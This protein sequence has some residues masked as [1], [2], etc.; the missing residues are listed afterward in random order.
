MTALA[1][2]PR[3]SPDPA[4]SALP[5]ARPRRGRGDLPVLAVPA[6]V[7][8]ALFMVGPVVAMIA[9]SFLSW[10]GMLATPTWTGLG[11]VRRVLADPVFWD[12]ARNSAVQILVG[13]PLMIGLAFLL[14]F[15]VVQKPRG[16]RVLRY[17]LFVPA[18]ISA[19]ATAM[20]FYAALNPDGLVNGM[21]S[22]I[23]IVGPAWLADERTAL[24]AVIA[25]ELWGG[26]GYSAVLL[27]ARLD[28]VDTS[29]M[30]AARLDGAGDWR[31]AWRMY[32]PIARDFIGV[33]AMLQFLSMLFTSAQT[34][35]L[36]TQGGPG[37]ATTTLS[38]LI[39]R[40]AFVE[41]DLGYSQAVGVVL[42][43]V[44]LIGM[45]A[46]RRLLRATH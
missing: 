1:S 31:I 16:H 43:V 36:L 6:L 25:V 11:N 42:F 18:L 23:G 27:A 35:L 12:A 24:G 41:A 37:T 15:H 30:E 38:Y 8:Y 7:W 20:V 26:I 22:G 28:G 39:Y 3:L 34:V 5:R 9:I 4:L 17:L 33:V 45:G 2:P 46:I 21:L 19:P 14:A 10:P 44:G 32:W 13:L 29:V 40:K